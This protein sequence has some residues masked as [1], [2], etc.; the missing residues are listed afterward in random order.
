MQP[1][2]PAIPT[3]SHIVTPPGKREGD[4]NRVDVLLDR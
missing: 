4:V 1:I 2:Y 3:L